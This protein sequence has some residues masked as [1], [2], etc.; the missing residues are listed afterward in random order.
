[1]EDGQ[2]LAGKSLVCI[3]GFRFVKSEGYAASRKG[4]DEYY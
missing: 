1:M 4:G 3:A 2:A